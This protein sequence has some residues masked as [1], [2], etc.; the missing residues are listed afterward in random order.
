MKYHYPGWSFDSIRKE[1]GREVIYSYQV[2]APR[3]QEDVDRTGG[4]Q[5]TRDHWSAS[6]NAGYYEDEE[7]HDLDTLLGQLVG[8]FWKG[9]SFAEV[10]KQFPAHIRQAF[11]AVVPKVKR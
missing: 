10:T 11:A 6:I 7:Y 4:V 2:W 5:S 3:T 8:G 9:D 1:H